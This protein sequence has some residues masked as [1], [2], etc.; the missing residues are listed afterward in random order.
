[1]EPVAQRIEQQPSKLSVAGSTPAGL[2]Q[3]MRDHVQHRGGLSKDDEG[4]PIMP[5]GAWAMMLQAADML[6]EYEALRNSL[7]R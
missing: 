2:A 5:N 3:R 1:M 4:K 6:D 7:S